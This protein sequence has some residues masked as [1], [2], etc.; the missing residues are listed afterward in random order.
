MSTTTKISNYK[1]IVNFEHSLRGDFENLNYNPT[2]KSSAIFFVITNK[3]IN[4]KISFLNYWKIKNANIDI[5]CQFTIRKQNG[6]KILRKFFKIS[7][8]TY[9]ISLGSLLKENLKISNFIGS[10]E[11]ELHSSYDLKYSFPAIDAIY[12]TKEGI[13]LV[14]SN[15]R[16]YDN[17]DDIKLNE[18][19]NQTQ[20]GFDI[21]LD[22]KNETFI[23]A[24]NGP[25][26]LYK[27]KLNIVFYNLQ[28][29]KLK[30]SI[31]FENIKP[32]QTIYLE[33]KNFKKLKKFLKNKRGFCKIDLPTQNIFNRILVGTIS[34]DKKN[35][36]TTHSY[37]D[38]SN[39]KD[40]IKT[41]NIS[42][43]EYH[44]YLPFN[45]I[46]N[47]DL[48]IVIYPIFSRTNL[49]IALEEFN[50]N[51]KRK[52]INKK[53][54]NI[55]KNFKEPKIIEVSSAILKAKNKAVDYNNVFC[56]N[57]TSEDN[58]IPSRFTFGFNY[59]QRSIGSN[60]SESMIVNHGK[61]I[62]GRGFYWG[63]VFCSKK[64]KTL[65]ALSSVNKLKNNSESK[66][67]L[68][69]M[70]IYGSEKIILTKKFNIKSPQGF[71]LDLDKLINSKYKKKDEIFWFTL[72]T[73]EK[74]ILCKHV[75]LSKFGHVCADHAF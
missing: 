41:S 46:K 53:L 11:L 47:V 26:N 48:E 63:P 9:K 13:S 22:S 40:F 12:E 25:V 72:E 23:T 34:N 51:G 69:K 7:N 2:F 65:I 8:N 10:I 18:S 68:V 60:I 31:Q 3:Y 45:L 19:L 17:L 33:L 64:I 28:G 54:I 66:S 59:K 50:K 56:L 35:I 58:L 52:I 1:K 70:N 43:E 49:K 71:N 32:Y 67:N 4:T 62:K 61:N 6:E 24:I 57:I 75:H 74:N 39:T 44:C 30:E 15:Q 38:C 42:K 27:K 16:V 36:T 14:H 5:S 21:H 37:Y 29:H 55:N 73:Q 20:T